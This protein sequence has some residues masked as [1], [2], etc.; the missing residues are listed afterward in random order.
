MRTGGKISAS[1]KGANSLPASTTPATTSG[2]VVQENSSRQTLGRFRASEATPLVVGGLMYISTPYQRVV[3]LEPETGREVWVWNSP[4]GGQ[5]SLRG[6]EYWPGDAHSPAEILFGT[7]DGKLIALN[8][9]TGL[10]IRSFGENGV[11]NLRTSQIMNGYPKNIYGMTSP[12]VVYRNLV[13]TGASV[14]EFPPLGPAGDVRA[15]NVT[16]GKLVWTFH[17]VPRPGEKGHDTWAGDSWKARSGTN[18]WGF[19]T[20]DTKR[21][22]VYMPFGAPTWDRYGGDR[23][24][25]DLF[26]TTLV[27]ADANTGKLLWYFQVVHHDIWD[28]DLEAPPLLLDVKRHGKAIPAVAVISKSGLLF[29]LNRVTGKPIYRVK[30]RPVP[31]SDT[32][33]ESAWPTQPFPVKPAP[34]GREGLTPD[35]IATITPELHQFCEHFVQSNHIRLGGPY[36]PVGYKTVTVSLPGTQGIVNWGGGSFDPTMGYLFVNTLD[37]GQVSSLIKTT[38]RPVPYGVGPLF[39]RFWDQ[40][41]RLPCQQPPWGSLVAVD[42]NRGKIVWRVPLGVTDSFPAGKQN[43]GRPNMG[44]SIVTAG[45][46]VFVGATDDGRIRAFDSHTGKELWVARL[47]AAAHA[48]PSTYLGKDGKQY[49]VI[50][51]TGGSFLADPI[52]SDSV[53]AYAISAGLFSQAAPPVPGSPSKDYSKTLTLPEGKGKD[54]TQRICGGC[55][56]TDVFVEQRHT[57]QEWSSIVDN[58]VTRGAEGTDEELDDVVGYLTKSFPP[59]NSTP[60]KE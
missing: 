14:Q 3:A 29:L 57:R 32:P 23:K 35:D 55:H 49:V 41:H 53:T 43:T 4:D 50:V 30:E 42:V 15:W 27:A 17:S 13:I 19:M 26:D 31:A 6:V 47:D 12:P 58:M 59:D 44:G 48:T 22:I 16:T 11:V 51:A 45:G 18:V 40:E 1:P 21:G 52:R 56:S 39:G 33:G 37:L 28:L 60:T 7:R 2:A 36:M 5:L 25:E 10:P 8:A 34:L 20:V 9:K 46:L 24:G 54:V 38:G